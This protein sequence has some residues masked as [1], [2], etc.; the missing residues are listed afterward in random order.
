[1]WPCEAKSPFYFGWHRS[2]LGE[3]LKLLRSVCVFVG[4]PS[5]DADTELNSAELTI[6]LLRK[7]GMD[8]VSIDFTKK[9]N[10][11]H[12][13]QCD[14]VNTHEAFEHYEDTHEVQDM[15]RCSRRDY[16]TPR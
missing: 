10:R 6:P 2:R 16:T 12:V 1:M 13:L 8:T 14:V 11:A 15:H 7:A 3:Y 4:A 9:Q 5:K